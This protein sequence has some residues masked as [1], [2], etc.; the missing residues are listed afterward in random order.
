M[1]GKGHE[2]ATA[3]L[4]KPAVPPCPHQEIIAL[5]A[6]HLPMGRQV[7]D[8]LWTGTRA[9]H[10]KARWRESPK[11]QSLEWWEKFFG[12]CAQSDFLTG[13]VPPRNGSKQFEVSL[14]WIVNPTNFAKIHEGAYA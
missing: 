14:D 11:R 4:S 13:K 2:P 5:Y 9:D 10:L 7:N 12:Y 6:K 8:E 3:G 1:E